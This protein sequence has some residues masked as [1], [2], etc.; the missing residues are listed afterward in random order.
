MRSVPPT[1]LPFASL[2]PKQ[3]RHLPTRLVRLSDPNA[4]QSMAMPAK[5]RSFASARSAS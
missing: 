1:G 2:N 5:G 3:T 4:D